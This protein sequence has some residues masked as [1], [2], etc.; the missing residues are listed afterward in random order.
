MG[1]ALS[2][3]PLAVAAV[4]ALTTAI[5][6]SFD[7]ATRVVKPARQHAAVGTWGPPTCSP[8]IFF[9]PVGD[10]RNALPNRELHR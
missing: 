10:R 9:C 1:E 4:V 8:V 5:G 6:A 7:V 2:F 3:V